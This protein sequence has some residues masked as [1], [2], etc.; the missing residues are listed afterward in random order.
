[1]D[2]EIYDMLSEIQ[3]MIEMSYQMMSDNND[4]LQVEIPPELLECYNKNAYRRNYIAMDYVHNMSK[5]VDEIQKMIDESR[6]QG[7]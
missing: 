6:Q 1:M 4:Y 7:E 5:L 2:N 3:I